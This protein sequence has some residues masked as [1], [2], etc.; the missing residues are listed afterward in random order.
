MSHNIRKPFGSWR[1]SHWT[2]LNFAHVCCCCLELFFEH[3]PKMNSPFYQHLSMACSF[4]SFSA[5]LACNKFKK[6]CYYYYYYY[7]H[8]YYE[9]IFLPFFRFS[10]FALM[11]PLHIYFINWGPNCKTICVMLASS[12]KTF[13]N[14][15]N[16]KT[17]K[18]WN[19]ACKTQKSNNH[20]NH[21]Y[22]WNDI[23]L[24]WEKP[25]RYGKT[26]AQAIKSITVV[27][28]DWL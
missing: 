22:F 5:F 13:L 2:T 16:N 1:R 7:Y 24:C 25:M 11:F 20:K 12:M 19:I 6:Y 27:C 10:L 21:K 14:K 17:K 9:L 23:V 4:L 15:I 28:C 18:E 3:F 8:H 26:K